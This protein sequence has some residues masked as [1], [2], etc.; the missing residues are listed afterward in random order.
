MLDKIGTETKVIGAIVVFTAVVLVGGVFLLTRQQSKESSIPE[1][2]I[3]ARGGIHWHPR[4]EIQI[5]GVKQEIPENL[6]MSG[7]IHQELHTH[8]GDAKDG[9]IHMEMKGLV[10]KDETRIAN[11][12]KIWG[13][14]FSQNQILDSVNND[15]GKVS[16]TVNGI[17]S[18]LFESYEMRDGDE[19]L[20]KYE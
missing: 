19:I 18:E 3:V 12:F 4:L 2:Q 10:T 7:Q 8:V 17:E 20:I 15:E 13:E 5:N 1:E 16:M 9:V 6:G 14:V 11:F